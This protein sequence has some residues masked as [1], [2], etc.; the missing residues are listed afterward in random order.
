MH[1]VTPAYAERR[2][3]AGSA[4]VVWLVIV[5]VAALLIYN[6]ARSCG[7]RCGYEGRWRGERRRLADVDVVAPPPSWGA[8]VQR[9][10]VAVSSRGAPQHEAEVMCG[11][12][13]DGSVPT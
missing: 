2:R 11:P 6:I 3:T 8:S 10:A 1:G 5:G 12:E 4:G 9:R 13:V 7:R